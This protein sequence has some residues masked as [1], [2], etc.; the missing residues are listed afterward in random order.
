MLMVRKVLDC[1]LLWLDDWTTLSVRPAANGYPTFFRDKEGLSGKGKGAPPSHSMTI[2]TGTLT[3]NSPM[4]QLAM[5]LTFTF[6]LTVHLPLFFFRASNVSSNFDAPTLKCDCSWNTLANIMH[7]YKHAANM[8]VQFWCLSMLKCCIQENKWT[9]F[10]FISPI[11][12]TWQQVTVYDFPLCWWNLNCFLIPELTITVWPSISNP[13]PSTFHFLSPI[14]YTQAFT[15]A[16]M[17]LKWCNS[18]RVC[19]CWH[20]QI[21]CM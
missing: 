4:G 20:K 7:L 14:I 3:S 17:T 1:N 19:T 8:H 11:Y 16:C 6:Y 13:S 10:Q 9:V 18:T 21:L 15:R 2:E 5:G 12:P